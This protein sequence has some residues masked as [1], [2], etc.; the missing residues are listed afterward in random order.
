[1]YSLLGF[2]T[3]RI[4]SY[5][6]KLS[7]RKCPF[8]FSTFSHKTE[9]GRF[10]RFIRLI[11]L[12]RQKRRAKPIS[13]YPEAVGSGRFECFN[14]NLSFYAVR[15]EDVGLSSRFSLLIFFFYLAPSKNFRV[16]GGTIIPDK[17]KRETTLPL[18][19]NEGRDSTQGYN[20]SKDSLFGLEKTEKE[21]RR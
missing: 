15:E 9:I 1:M 21:T 2:L 16:E 13:V 4:L 8:F 10:S 5:F 18:G 19:L 20:W 6:D 12:R 17:E 11:R 3:K 14:E 7:R